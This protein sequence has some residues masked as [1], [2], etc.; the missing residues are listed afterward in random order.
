[1]INIRG[2][3]RDKDSCINIYYNMDKGGT[4]KVK[5][6]PVDSDNV[7]RIITDSVRM[8]NII[9]KRFRGFIYEIDIQEIE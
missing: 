5:V 9:N 2:N 6:R 1:M 8:I 3:I 7:R 4:T